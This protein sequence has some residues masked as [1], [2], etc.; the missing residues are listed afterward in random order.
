M[1][2]RLAK[3]FSYVQGDFSAGETYER[4]AKTIKGAK[5]PVFYLE[6]PPSLFGMTIKGST[7]PA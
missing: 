4:V 1:F 6:I 2:N 3:R 7:M 5:S